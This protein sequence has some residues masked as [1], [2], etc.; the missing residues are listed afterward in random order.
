MKKL[1]IMLLAGVLAAGSALALDDIIEL[2]GEIKTGVYLEQKVLEGNET[3]KNTILNYDGDSG[4]LGSRIRFGISL[5]TK[6]VGLRTRFSQE[7][8]T[9]RPNGINDTSLAFIKTDFA[10][11]YGN[12]FNGRFKISA[13]MLGESPWGTG[14][15]EIGKELETTGIGDP[16]T[17]IRLEW[18][19]L[20]VLRG[21]N[22]GIVLNRADEAVPVGAKEMFADLFMESILGIAYE[23]PYLAFSFAYRF[24]RGLASPAAT[25]DG[26]K[27]AYRV[28]ERLLWRLVPGMSISANGYCQGINAGGDRSRSTPGYVINWLYISYAPEYFSSGMNVGYNDGFEINAQKLEFR[29]Y[30]YYNIISNH[31]IAG[32]MGGFETGFNGGKAFQDTFYNF[33]FVEPQVK[34]IVNPNFYIALVYRFQS[35]AFET[36]SYKDQVTNWVNLR[37]SFA[38]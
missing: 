34:V 12:L 38:F 31:L 35:G 2:S 23:N 18:K 37:L 21:L 20:G 15:P 4:P 10:Y 32:L 5:N 11:V 28:E 16:I 17:G 3:S 33:W 29:P 22:L 13:G 36:E 27:F 26:E 30:F 7:N 24:D 9:Y 25:L 19:P 6:G 8:F 1:I 14:G